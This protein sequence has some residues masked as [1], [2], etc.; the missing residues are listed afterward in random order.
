MP[1]LVTIPHDL[2]TIVDAFDPPQVRKP[3]WHVTDL[4]KA[5]DAIA[6]GIEVPNGGWLFEGDT[7]GLMSW[8]RMW[9]GAVREWV[10]IRAGDMGL[11]FWAPE[12]GSPGIETED[13]IANL[14]GELIA[15]NHPPDL[16]ASG[17]G[18]T[19]SVAV[20]EMKATTTADTN[21]LTKPNWMCQT[22]AYCHM[23][24]VTQV[25]F[26]V[27]HMPRRGAPEA[28][29]Y[30]HIVTFEPWEIAENW[31]MLISTK[32]YLESRGIKLWLEN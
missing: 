27:L 12:P 19:T 32:E 8:G 31:Q 11:S 22:K 17:I 14:D 9:E 28:R 29:V 7:S 1:H 10:S 13:I 5:A 23:I 26:I 25:W 4:K 20:V 2:S 24:G 6:K 15:F 18:L 21:P 16:A 30:Q 3:G